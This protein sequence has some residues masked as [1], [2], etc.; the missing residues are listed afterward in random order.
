LL[1]I[2]QV[3]GQRVVAAMREPITRLAERAAAATADDMWSFTPGL[4]IAGL[5]HAD[6][7]RRLFRS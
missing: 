3:E 1:P 7:E 4:E 5:R 6:L 2:G